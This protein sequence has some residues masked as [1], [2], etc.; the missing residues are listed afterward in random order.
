[1]F[2]AKTFFVVVLIL[3]S[4]VHCRT[5]PPSVR[6]FPAPVETSPS[7]PSLSLPPPPPPDPKLDGKQIEEIAKPI[8]EIVKLKL[9]PQWIIDTTTICA[10]FTLVSTCLGLAKLV[11]DV[12]EK[13]NKSTP[14][15]APNPIYFRLNVATD[16]STSTA[17]V[18]PQGSLHSRIRENQDRNQTN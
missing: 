16:D 3:L 2:T 10:V 5:A 18:H 7:P 15:H 17:P 6:T 9:A 13:C 14:T 1:M 11:M 8:D 12:I 4:E